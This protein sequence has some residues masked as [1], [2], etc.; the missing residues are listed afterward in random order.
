MREREREIW[1][2]GRVNN[3]L[4]IINN[5]NNNKMNNN[6]RYSNT[7]EIFNIN[8]DDNNWSTLLGVWADSY[9]FSFQQNNLV[10]KNIITYFYI[11]V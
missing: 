3:E 10:F 5:S 6:T 2:M 7:T 9:L 8:T 1:I 11:V 4:Q